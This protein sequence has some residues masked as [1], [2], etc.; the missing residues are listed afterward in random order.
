MRPSE[1]LLVAYFVYTAVLAW[2]LSIPAPY[3]TVAALL[4]LTIFAGLALLAWAHSLR[5]RPYLGAIRDWFPFPLLLLTYREIG[6]FAQPAYT[7]PLEHRWVQWDRA[8]LHGGLTGA[9]ELLGPVM[10]AILEIAYMLVYTLA[11]FAVA[12]LYVYGKRDRVEALLFPYVLAVV[13][14]YAPFPLWPSEPPRAVFPGQDFPAYE[15]IFRRFNWWYLGGQG[16]HTSV[17]PSTHVA[18]A[19]AVAFAMWRVLPEHKWVGR[20]LLVMAVLVATAV[21]YGRYHYLAD[22]AAGLFMALVTVA[23]GRMRVAVAAR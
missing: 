11:P 9:V 12:M 20:Y 16:I 14:W 18:S 4:N 13:L 7:H 5:N 22:A 10:P 2:A 1:W 19:F 8:V 6:W 17:F 21:V 23:V 3:P 15:S